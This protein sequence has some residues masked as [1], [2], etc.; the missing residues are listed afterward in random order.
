MVKRKLKW[1]ERPRYVISMLA[2]VGALGAAVVTL[3]DYIKLPETTEALAGQVEEHDEHLDTIQGYIDINQAII[4]ANNQ[5]Q[6]Q[7]QQYYPQQQQMPPMPKMP[8][9][10]EEPP[11]RCYDWWEEEQYEVDCYT[12]EWL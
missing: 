12:W 7:Q 8:P 9:K 6:Q 4:E 5:W 2:L 1:Y 3:A 11:R 10:Y